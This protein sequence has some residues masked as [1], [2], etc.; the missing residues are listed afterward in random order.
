MLARLC[1]LEPRSTLALAAWFTAHRSRDRRLVRAGSSCCVLTR[2]EPLVWLGYP[3][4]C[5]PGDASALAEVIE[6][7][8]VIGLDGQPED[9]DPLL[10]HLE[11]VGETTRFRRMVVPAQECGWEPS[12]P[13]T[14]M[15][16][17]VDIDS[18]VE[19][20]EGYEVRFVSGS[21]S[22]RRLLERS[23]ASH[24]VI[25][26]DRGDGIDGALLTGGLT[27]GYLV[28]E[29]ARVAP[30]ARGQGISWTLISKV[31]E[32]A[33]AYGVGLMGS[34]SHDNPMS[35]PEDRGPIEAQVSVNL[36]LPDRVPAE[37]SV[38]RLALRVSRR[39]LA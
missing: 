10:P 34:M 12:A 29:H 16:T 22:R 6:R 27:P 28:L 24:A 11:R 20:F 7:T 23:I 8:P 32:I 37:R 4:L 38:R 21:R 36:R 1:E 9:I 13:G 26:H 2:R 17:P 15:A 18:L 19:L 5:D 30:D 3:V 14:R 31:V 39:M 25:V 35:P 33:Q